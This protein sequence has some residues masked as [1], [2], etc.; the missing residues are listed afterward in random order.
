MSS[1]N[2]AIMP[3]T[4]RITLVGDGSRSTLGAIRNKAAANGF[5]SGAGTDSFAGRRARIFADLVAKTM[6]LSRGGHEG[7]NDSNLRAGVS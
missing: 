5:V 2:T 7:G 1:P 4:I 3:G 6:L